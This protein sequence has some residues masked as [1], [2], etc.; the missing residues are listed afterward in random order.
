MIRLK[1]YMVMA[2]PGVDQIAE[3]VFIRSPIELSFYTA[4]HGEAEQHDT[5]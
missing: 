4:T 3:A 1:F 5:V 2:L